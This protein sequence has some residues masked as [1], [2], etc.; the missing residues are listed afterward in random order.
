MTQTSRDM[1][2]VD[3]AVALLNAPPSVIGAPP[4]AF[5]AFAIGFEAQADFQPVFDLQDLQDLRVTCIPADEA[6]TLLTHQKTQLDVS[7]DVWIQKH[8]ADAAEARMLMFVCEQM[9]TLLKLPA[10]VGP[11]S[12]ADGSH[13]SWIGMTARPLW[14]PEHMQKKNVFTRVLTFTYRT[15]IPR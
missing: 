15:K 9:K 6:D 13:A 7:V 12:L 3:A 5:A 14:H 10:G 11:M 2:I 8:F 1:D 4:T